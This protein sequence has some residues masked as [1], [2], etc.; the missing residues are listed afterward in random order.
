[1]EVVAGDPVAA[2]GAGIGLCRR[3]I[4]RGFPKKADLTII[5]SFPYTQGP[6]IMKP[7]APATLI[8]K[9]G[10]VVILAAHCTAPLP[11]I[12]LEGCERF[13][14]RYGGRLREGVLELFGSNRRIIEEGAPELNMSV[15]QALLG[16]NDFTV[17]LLSDDIPR[18]AAERV[19]FRHARDLK[20]AFA[21]S[22]T[23]LTG[24]EV[25]IVPSG[26]VILPVVE[27]TPR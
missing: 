26:G 5:S 14:R 10:G 16:Q 22:A 18:E 1:Y 6:Q 21:L 19:G 12:Y 4:S 15:A 24:P 27:A 9:T 3:I 2:H 23:L 20:E 17:I 13:R 11:E 8:T 7:L 25:H